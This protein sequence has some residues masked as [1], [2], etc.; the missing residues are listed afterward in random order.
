MTQAMASHSTADRC[1]F[2]RIRPIRAATAGSRLIQTPKTRAGIRRST[3]SSSQ[4]GTTE[5]RT[6]IAAPSPTTFGPN[7]ARCPTPNGVTRTA[8]TV[9][10]MTRPADPENRCPL[11]R[12]SRM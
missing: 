5:D 8:A 9:I 2:S 11:A 3:S 6:P 1:W 10:A 4:Y 7:I 12:D